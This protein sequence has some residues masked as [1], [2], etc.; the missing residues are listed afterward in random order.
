MPGYNPFVNAAAPALQGR[1]A[2]NAPLT[3]SAVTVPARPGFGAPSM[4]GGIGPGV[5]LPGSVAPPAPGSQPPAVGQPMGAFAPGMAMGAPGAQMGP[6]FNPAQPS[7]TGAM[8]GGVSGFGQP[9]GGT[10]GRGPFGG[11]GGPGGQGRR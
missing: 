11:L 7:T 9:G 5:G 8:G 3:S 4:P 1:S 2:N 10:W 6:G